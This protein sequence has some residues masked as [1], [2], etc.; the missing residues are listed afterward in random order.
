MNEKT[1]CELNSELILSSLACGDPYLRRN[2]IGASDAPI[3]MGVSPWRTPLQLYKEKIGLE[4]AQEE[5][6]HMKR[7]KDLEDEARLRFI[8][9]TGIQVLPKRIFHPEIEYMMASLD[10][11]DPTGKYI[12]EIKCPLSHYN[13]LCGEVPKHYYP[14]LQH[15]MIVAD[16]NKMFYFSYT[17]D[18]FQVVECY[19]DEKYCK[20]LLEKESEFWSCVSNGIEPEMTDRDLVQKND[21]NWIILSGEWNS[22]Q[23]SKSQILERE[24]QLRNQLI[25]LCGGKSSF[26]N[27]VRVKK[28]VRK[29]N[30]D[31][32]NIF[33]LSNVDLEKYRKQNSEYWKISK[34]E[35]E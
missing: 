5:N 4:G 8:E 27:G 12:V 3:I 7:G 19:R 9:A 15:Q 35:E 21:L 13:S 30:I 2:Y 11:I 1:E 17:P 34:I 6:A 28:C 14:Q 32:S 20:L 10:G 29:G 24:E 22:V 33:E 25:E 18:S 23:K 16:V 26:G 31:Y